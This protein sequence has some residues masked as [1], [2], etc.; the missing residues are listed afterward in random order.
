LLCLNDLHEMSWYSASSGQ[1][2]DN[3]LETID[4]DTDRFTMSMI[5][6]REVEGLFRLGYET[7]VIG[8]DMDASEKSFL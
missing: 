3:V 6:N 1:V 8:R 2:F 7:W 5:M 4:R